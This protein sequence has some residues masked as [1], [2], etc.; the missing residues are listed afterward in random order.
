VREIFRHE[1][2]TPKH[3]PEFTTIGLYQAYIRF[4]ACWTWWWE[5]EDRMAERVSRPGGA[6]PG[7][8]IDLEL[9]AIA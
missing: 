4:P 2:W 5:D 8:E 7:Q 3:N 1:A 6:L 9:G